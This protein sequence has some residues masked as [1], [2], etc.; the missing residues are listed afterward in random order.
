MS[1]EA[2]SSVVNST[3]ERESRYGFELTPRRQLVIVEGRGATVT[4]DRGRRYIDCVAGHG[5]ALIGHCN[6]AV[7]AAITAQAQRLISCPISLYNDVRAEL[8]EQLV[9]IAPPRLERAFLCNSGTE[10]VEAALKLAR[11]TTGRTRLVAARGGFHGRTMG[12][13]SATFEPHYREPFE[14]LVPGVE[15]VPFNDA[16]RL[17]AAVDGHTAAVIL[18]AVQ[19]EGGV[20]VARHDYLRAA[21]RLCDD[22]GA[23]LILDEVQTGLGRTGRM[24]ACEHSGIEPDLLCLA[25]GLAGGVPMGAVLCAD[26]ITVPTG[27]HGTT[28]GGNPLACAAGLATVRYILENRLPEEAARKGQTLRDRLRELDLGVVREVRGLGLMV[29]IALKTRV[30]P[31]LDA[32]TERGVL[33]LPAGASVLRLLPP[34]VISDDEIERVVEAVGGALAD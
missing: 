24:F 1:A 29:G 12:A 32:L 3:V 6:P 25:K 34:L 28:Y 21:R 16:E 26:R 7:V 23:L 8:L 14:P 5:V 27:G 30:R 11:T 33:G 18:E 20:H 2:A 17:A 4:D 22:H 19:G 13:L 31:Y 10:A 9:G 15:F